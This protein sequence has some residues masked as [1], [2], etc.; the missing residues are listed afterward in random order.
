MLILKPRSTLSSS[1]EEGE[2]S[3]LASASDLMIGLLF[4]FIILVVVLALEQ[5]RQQGEL[6]AVKG[7]A[8]PRASVTEVI[9]QAL[10]DARLDVRVDP[11]SGVISLPSDTLFA[12]GSSSLSVPATQAIRDA[13]E[14][15]ATVLPCYVASERPR[16]SDRQCA[17]NRGWH[18]IDTIFLEG[19]TDSVVN[20]K[21]GG[22]L[23]LSFDRARAI[24]QVVLGDGSP[25]EPF[26]NAAGQPIFSYSAYGA[27]RLLPGIDGTSAQNRRVDLRIVLKY[28]SINDTLE[29]LKRVE[30]G[31]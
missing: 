26:R 24:Q 5:G 28:Q 21:P 6:N 2:G 25:L 18:E 3:Y 1:R 14:R 16:V 17:K 13:R 9:G 22:N 30:G 31:T 4:I 29:N 10:K 7:A 19:H 23:G 12:L 15:L 11:A 20:L 8:D 27:D